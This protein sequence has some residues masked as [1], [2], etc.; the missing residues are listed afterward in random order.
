MEDWRICGGLEDLLVNYLVKI[1]GL[2]DF[3][4]IGGFL[5]DW[6]ICGGLEDFFLIGGSERMDYFW[7]GNPPPARTQP[8]RKEK[9][10]T[11]DGSAERRQ[12]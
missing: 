12:S 11:A 9:P 2:E 8:H 10:L 3:W 4:R 5:E 7:T 1:G 6:R